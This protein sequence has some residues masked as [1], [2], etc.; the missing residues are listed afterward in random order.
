MG[1]VA[2]AGTRAW[3]DEIALGTMLT[4]IDLTAADQENISVETFASTGRPQVV[5]NHT[6]MAGI[7][8]LFDGDDDSFDEQVFA[9]FTTDEQHYLL[10]ALG[11]ATEGT[12]CYEQE[13]RLK[14]QMRSA[15]QG[16]AFLLN[17]DATGAGRIVRGHILRSATVTGTGNGTG[18]N[19][20][21][22]TSGQLFMVVYRVIAI[23]GGAITLQYHSSTDD[24]GGDAYSSVAALASGSLAAVGVTPKTTTSAMEAWGRITVSAMTASSATIL[25]SAGVAPTT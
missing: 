18:Q 8:G 3:L 9:N 24:G 16:A 10:T 17:F 25:V 19:L 15:K 20:G 21:A 23:T 12:V 13:V 1:K 5:G 11:A 22:T 6:H 7:S 4:A 14:D 2:A